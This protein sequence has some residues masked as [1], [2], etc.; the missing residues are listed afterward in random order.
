MGGAF[1]TKISFFRAGETA[2][3]AAAAA[4]KSSLCV[5]A[6]WQVP[7]TRYIC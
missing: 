1:I 4:P 2:R 6:G 7:D 5:A 3:T